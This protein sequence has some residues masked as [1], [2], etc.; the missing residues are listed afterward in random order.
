M[1]C[2]GHL[3][4]SKLKCTLSSLHPPQSNQMKRT[5]SAMHSQFPT[6]CVEY[7]EGSIS[8]IFWQ[9]D[10]KLLWKKATPIL[11]LQCN[12]KKSKAKQNK[13]N[14]YVFATKMRN[15]QATKK[16][17]TNAGF[18]LLLIYQ[19]IWSVSA[20]IPIAQS[21][22]ESGMGWAQIKIS[23][24]TH[25]IQRLA[26]FGS[27]VSLTNKTFAMVC[28]MGGWF[29]IPKLHRFLFFGE[30]GLSMEQ[31][32]VIVSKW[33]IAKAVCFWEHTKKQ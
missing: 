4:P 20:T 33:P 18:Y 13:F 22:K 11:L 29:Q 19:Y 14:I 2:V 5:L 10:K 15:E 1:L 17:A 21:Y 6:T 32:F 3:N 24:T 12:A 25:N 31:V 7:T 16:W 30:V 28:M 8:N 23:L 9:C 26:F 27:L